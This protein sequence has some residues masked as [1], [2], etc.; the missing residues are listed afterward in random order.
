ML[1]SF[2]SWYPFDNYFL[3]CCLAIH[4]VFGIKFWRMLLATL[5]LKYMANISSYICFLGW[6]KIQKIQSWELFIDHV[7]SL[8]DLQMGKLRP[9]RVQWFSI[10]C[11]WL[12]VWVFKAGGSGPDP[13]LLSCVT[14]RN[15]H[16]RSTNFI[17]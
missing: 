11:V 17:C 5:R 16:E 2:H 14:L 15:L 12:R 13:P 9:R 8:H 3:A 7:F 6:M 4:N 1:K 10:W